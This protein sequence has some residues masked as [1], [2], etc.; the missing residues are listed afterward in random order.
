MIIVGHRGAKAEAPENTV[1]S[2]EAAYKV[3]IRHF[4]LD[5]QLSKD[6]ELIVIHDNSVDR[7][8]GVKGKV[9][10]LNAAELTA[11]DAG[12]HIP[13]WYAPAPIP[14]LGEVL[15][16]IPEF[17]SIQFEVKTDSRGRLNTL[18][19]RLVELI[20]KRQLFGRIVVTSSNTWVLQQVKRLNQT[21]DTGYVAQKRF[22]SPVQTAIKLNCSLLALYHKLADEELIRD[23]QKA[24]ILVS[25]WTVNTIPEINALQAIG[26]HSVITDYPQHVLKHYL[27]QPELNFH[28]Q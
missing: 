12:H 2:F 11:L 19:N 22:P 8:T 21:I 10:D 9:A 20:Q 7:T 25:T 5:I 17:Q 1:I 14:T 24:G 26:V 13:P 3:G 16:A 27:S 23:C 4:E 18:C 15:D 28:V 6:G